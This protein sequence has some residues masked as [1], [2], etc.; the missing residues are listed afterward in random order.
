MS[1]EP[2]SGDPL[3]PHRRAL[4]GYVDE[5]GRRTE[6]MQHAAAGL[7]AEDRKRAVNRVDGS[8]ERF[9]KEV[10][11]A[12]LEYAARRV[13][14]AGV[15]AGPD[16]ARE[17]LEGYGKHFGSERAEQIRNRGR[18]LYREARR[19]SANW[20][21][22]QRVAHDQSLPSADRLR[23]LVGD[24]AQ[25]H[26]RFAALELALRGAEHS[27]ETSADPRGR[28]DSD[29]S[30]PEAGEEPAVPSVAARMRRILGPEF[31]DIEV[32]ARVLA[33][34][35]QERPGEWIRAS[36]EQFRADLEP[37]LHE[38]LQQVLRLE[39]E[40][41]HASAGQA[42]VGTVP[43][44]LAQMTTR[45]LLPIAKEANL[46]GRSRMKK[47][48]LVAALEGI[49]EQAGNS[50]AVEAIDDQIKE[51][52]ETWVRENGS[53]AVVHLSAEYE[54]QRRQAE[55]TAQ[56]PV[57]LSVQ[58]SF[59]EA[60]ELLGEQRAGAIED[61]TRSARKVV[62]AWG[63]AE[64]QAARAELGDPFKGLDP[65]GAR[66]AA[67]REV[68]RDRIAKDLALR[69]RLATEATAEADGL[70]RAE[71][72]RD[73]LGRKDTARVQETLADGQREKLAAWE[74]EEAPRRRE[75][76]HPDRFVKRYGAQAGQALAIEAKLAERDLEI[77]S[78]RAAEAPVQAAEVSASEV[79]ARAHVADVGSGIR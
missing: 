22:T 18:D 64:L 60:R 16:K 76:S 42:G 38:T 58:A 61:E 39:S 47:A 73:R 79:E 46:P 67:A 28:D 77:P 4:G 56:R 37:K 68:E 15:I 34:D 7:G 25:E 74:V 8:L 10:E 2:R 21:R 65:A 32:I 55:R 26:A 62:G 29:R 44:G 3:D 72:W 45:Q 40:R 71:R 9:A 13:A 31:K 23:G 50:S 11:K 59:A 19:G 49:R 36:R 27:V 6:A 17:F 35:A 12:Q 1:E 75:R 20:L 66:H 78:P 41:E 69:E 24:R 52:R 63:T 70:T 53:R 54:L 14:L 43:S 33:D 30:V 48:D 5:L 57:E 51:L